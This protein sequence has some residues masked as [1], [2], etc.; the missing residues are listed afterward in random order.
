MMTAADRESTFAPPPLEVGE[1]HVWYFALAVDAALL[2]TLRQRLDAIEKARA[3]RFYRVVH[4]DRFTVGR[5]TL[6]QILAAYA[7]N[8]PEAVCFSYGASGKPELASCD[9]GQDL[10]F[11]LSHTGDFGACAVARGAALGMD[12]EALRPCPDFLKIAKRFFAPDEVAALESLPERDQ[13]PGFYQCWTAKE[14]LVKAWG[15]GLTVPLDR[16]SVQVEPDRTMLRR[17]S[18]PA[19]G[20]VDWQVQ[21]VPAPPTLIAS[22]A[23]D[24]EPK[25]VQVGNT[26][27]LP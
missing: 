25:T 9:Q 1:I 18:L 10:H 22:V 4:R 2:P 27:A 24:G 12:I 23:Y 16:F 17:L 11:N 21:A 6:R 8:T 14:A 7:G 5:A 13:L 19:A 15:A 26:Q 20:T 3:D